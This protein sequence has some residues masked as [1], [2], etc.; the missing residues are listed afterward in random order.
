MYIKFDRNYLKQ[1]KIT[2]NHGK[3]V[4][5]YIVYKTIKTNP[6]SN[7]YPIVQNCFVGEIGFIKNSTINE[8]KY[9]GYGIRFDS[10]GTFSHSSGGFG[11]NVLIFGVDM[12]SSVHTNNK[13]LNISTTLYAGKMYSVNFTENEKKSCLSLHNNGSNSYLF[14]NGTGLLNLK[15]EN[16]E[17]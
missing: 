3:K 8:F 1:E 7:S 4:N 15:Q 11:L 5:I 17:W 10:K 12:S 16:L 6:I 14:V 2:F 13:I 9:N